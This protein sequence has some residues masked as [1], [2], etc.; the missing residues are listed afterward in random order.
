MAGKTF[1]AVVTDGQLRHKQSLEAF[2][3]QEVYVTLVAKPFSASPCQRTG[4]VRDDELPGG[5]DVE[6]DLYVKIPLTGEVVPEALVVEGPSIRPC[7]ILPE[8]SPDE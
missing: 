6:H 3:G 8:D 5:M 4:P 7:I 2:E 1:P